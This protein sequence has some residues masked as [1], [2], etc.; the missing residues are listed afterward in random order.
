STRPRSRR[1]Q[2]AMPYAAPFCARWPRR[3]QRS[4]SGRRIRRPASSPVVSTRSGLAAREVAGG[5]EANPAAPAERS[6]FYGRTLSRLL[7]DGL[8]RRDMSVLVVCGGEADR[9]AFLGAGFENVTISN[10]GAGDEDAFTPYAWSVLDAEDLSCE[11]G[12][13]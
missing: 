2:A 9:E 12:A 6:G 13:F 8:I 11:N 1:L 5:T 3:R 7:A 10:L 4:A